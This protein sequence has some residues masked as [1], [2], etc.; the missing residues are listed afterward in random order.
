MKAIF[1]NEYI[2]EDEMV[3]QHIDVLGP[4]PTSW[5]ERWEGRGEFF[6]QDARPTEGREIWPALEQAFERGVQD[7]RRRL[8]K[9][10]FGE[11]ETRAILNL[12]RQMLAFQPKERPTIEEVLESEWMVRWVLPDLKSCR[13]SK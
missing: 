6:D 1:S 12:I 10:V 2:T 3:S 5:W 11:E 13:N 7:Y 4:M 9:G 8:Q